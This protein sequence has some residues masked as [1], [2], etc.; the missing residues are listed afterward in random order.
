MPRKTLSPE[1][2]RQWA[3]D[4]YLLLNGILGKKELA[5]FGR[6][7]DRLYRRHARPGKKTNLKKS[8]DRRNVLGDDDLFIELMDHPATFDLVLDILGPNTGV[9]P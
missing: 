5:Q 7:V 2:R 6:V 1:Q 9:A 8:L 4:G 3:T